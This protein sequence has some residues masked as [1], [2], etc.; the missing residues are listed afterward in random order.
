MCFLIESSNQ[1]TEFQVSL[2]A[3]IQHVADRLSKHVAPIA[4]L[5]RIEKKKALCS[6]HDWVLRPC[7]CSF[8]RDQLQCSSNRFRPRIRS[9]RGLAS[10]RRRERGKR[11]ER[12]LPLEE[13]WI[14]RVT[15]PARSQRWSR[16]H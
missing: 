2:P 9:F 11:G 10:N 15:E 16:C 1:V 4:V 5:Q 3:S 7:R 12:R 8:L 6:H 14:L 13:S